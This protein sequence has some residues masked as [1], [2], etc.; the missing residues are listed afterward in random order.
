MCASLETFYDDQRIHMILYQEKMSVNSCKEDIPILFNINLIL[1][2]LNYKTIIWLPP[3]YS[4]NE[5]PT[6]MS[7]LLSN[8]ENVFLLL[9]FKVR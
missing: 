2:I 6:I 3:I 9:H 5:Y 1:L 7:F 8:K 4:K